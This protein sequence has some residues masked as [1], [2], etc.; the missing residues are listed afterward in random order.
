MTILLTHSLKLADSH[1]VQPEE[2]E[3]SL[4]VTDEILARA[5]FKKAATPRSSNLHQ[6][7][8]LLPPPP[9]QPTT[10]ASASISTL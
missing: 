3:E 2:F 4:E 9:A 1:V 7:I 6:T 5:I 10:S 8:R